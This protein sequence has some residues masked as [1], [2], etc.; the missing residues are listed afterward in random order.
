MRQTSPNLPNVFIR[1]TVSHV[2]ID[3]LLSLGLV[4]LVSASGSR[5]TPSRYSIDD[6]DYSVRFL[7]ECFA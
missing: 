3:R 4:M 2:Q 6:G 1:T 5:P 7:I